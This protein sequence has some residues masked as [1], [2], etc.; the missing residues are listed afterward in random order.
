MQRIIIGLGTG[1]CGT[2]SLAY[3]LAK[4]LDTKARHEGCELPWIM[5]EEELA[6]NLAKTTRTQRS[7]VCDVASYWL[8]YV[9]ELLLIA[10]NTRF[11]CLRRPRTEFAVSMMRKTQKDLCCSRVDGW[12]GCFPNLHTESVIGKARQDGF[13]QYWDIYNEKT[14]SLNEKYECFKI[15]ETVD[16]NSPEKQFEILTHCGYSNPV[17]DTTI[18]RNKKST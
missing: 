1:R 17:I 8:S 3:L 15:F 9:E 2:H 13:E 4:Q 12:F 10:P 5:D 7:I 16:L 6:R 14:L 11:I 18:W